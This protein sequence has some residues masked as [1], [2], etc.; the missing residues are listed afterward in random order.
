MK[1]RSLY[2]VNLADI[3]QRVEKGVLQF[4][5]ET[6]IDLVNDLT[7]LFI[8]RVF[9]EMAEIYKTQHEA[10]VAFY[11]DDDKR[12]Y[13]LDCEGIVNYKRFFRIM[14]KEVKFPVIMANLP[15]EW[16]ANMMKKDC[17]EY[18]EVIANHRSFA[19]LFPK[20]KK[21]IER[22]KFYRLGKEVVEN[23]QN[24]CIMLLSL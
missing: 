6:G 18:D 10:F 12:L 16:F 21:V 2:L 9:L 14:E 4:M 7:N 1:I 8:S 13:L 20:L 22:M 23:L 15:Y 11:L 5:A 17:P 19:E 3:I 24:R